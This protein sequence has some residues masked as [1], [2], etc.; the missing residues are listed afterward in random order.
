MAVD[1]GRMDGTRL[2]VTVNIIV[3]DHCVAFPIMAIV[4]KSFT[5]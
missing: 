4:K 2:V 5:V 1:G 3:V